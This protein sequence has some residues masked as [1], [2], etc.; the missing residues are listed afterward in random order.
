MRSQN[1]VVRLG[2]HE[3]EGCVVELE[4]GIVMAAAWSKGVAGTHPSVP[5]THDSSF[6]QNHVVLRQGHHRV[7][8]WL[9]PY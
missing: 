4:V 5:I 7:E 2:G 1:L 9:D 8:G 6:M 3:H